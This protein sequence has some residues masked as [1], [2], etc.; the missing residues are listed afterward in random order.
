MRNTVVHGLAPPYAGTIC[1]EHVKEFVDEVVLVSDSE[2]IEA[3]RVLYEHH[4]QVVEVRAM[5][6]RC[7]LPV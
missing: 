7:V 2:V 1:Y 4:H 3:V 5:R 6:W